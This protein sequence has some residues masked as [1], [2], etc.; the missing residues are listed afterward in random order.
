MKYQLSL[1]GSQVI[2]SLLGVLAG[3]VLGMWNL[4]L[5]ARI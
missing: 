4:I 2:W 1:T 5:W 3:A